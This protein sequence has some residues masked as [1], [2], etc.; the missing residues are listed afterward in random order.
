MMV[1]MMMIVT[2]DSQGSGDHDN[3]KAKAIRAD[4]LDLDFWRHFSF[5]KILVLMTFHF[6]R[7][8]SIAEI[9][10]LVTVQFCDISGLVTVKLW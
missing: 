5:S 1:I 2:P 3:D 6:G 4:L 7:H 10:V 9:S 8:F